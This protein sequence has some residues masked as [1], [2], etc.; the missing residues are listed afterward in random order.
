MNICNTDVTRE[1][2]RRFE[3]GRY[4]DH[5]RIEKKH[6]RPGGI[7]ILVLPIIYIFIIIII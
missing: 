3:S 7:L 5:K 6:V 1:L 2:D 4:C